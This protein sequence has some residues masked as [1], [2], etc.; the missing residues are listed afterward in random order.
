MS[1][2]PIKRYRNFYEC[3]D[4]GTTWQDEWSCKCDDRCPTCTKEIEPYKSEDLRP[5]EDLTNADLIAQVL[6]IAREDIYTDAPECAER[7]EEL[8]FLLEELST[9]QF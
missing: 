1:D 4:D 3:P 7:V 2:G 5:F 8:G 9:R 6:G